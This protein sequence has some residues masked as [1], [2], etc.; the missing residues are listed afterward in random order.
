MPLG[1]DI[2]LAKP[3]VPPSLD[4]ETLVCMR[5][6]PN[7]DEMDDCNESSSDEDEKKGGLPGTFPG[8]TST[9]SNHNSYY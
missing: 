1:R 3:F 4:D 7:V 5:A 9:A 6:P 2:H 8:S